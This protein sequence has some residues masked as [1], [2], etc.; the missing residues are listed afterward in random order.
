MEVTIT[1]GNFNSYKNGDKPLVVDLWATWCGPCRALA[2]TIAELAQDYDGKIVVG[3]CDV[4]E[5][6]DIAMEFG[7]RNIP[8]ILFFKDGKLVDKFV[9]AASKSKLDEKF[10]ALL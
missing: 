1:T 7:V 10:K 2:P 3:K 5:N 6:N 4:E 8:T 9:G